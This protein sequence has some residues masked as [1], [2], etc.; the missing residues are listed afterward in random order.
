MTNLRPD[1][2]ELLGG[3][4][5]VDG[6]VVAD[7][8][9]TRI[10]ALIRDALQKVTT[11]ADGWKTLYRDPEDGRFWELFYPHGELHGGGPPALRELNAHEARSIYKLEQ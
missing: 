1:E 9:T 3:W 8:T 11:S 2:G 6:K 4:T 10:R 5:E 7:A